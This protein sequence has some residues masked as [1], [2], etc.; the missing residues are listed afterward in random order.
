MSGIVRGPTTWSLS[1]DIDGYR[2]YTLEHL[3][4][5]SDI[6]DGP[7][8]AL[9][10]P[11][12]PISGATWIIGTEEDLFVYCTSE[13]EVT[14]IK[15]DNEPG[16]FWKVT[17]KFTNRPHKRCNDSNFDNP[18]DEPPRLSGSF[19][20]F[21]QRVFFDKDNKLLAS[22]SY[23]AF[24]VEIELPNP[25]VQIGLNYPTLP[26]ED[27]A[28]MVNSVNN[29]ALWGL[30]ARCVK[31][32]NVRWQRNIFGTCSYYYTVDYEFEINYNTWDIVQADRG[33]RIYNGSGSVTDP[34]SY[35]PYQDPKSKEYTTVYLNGSGGKLT[36]GNSPV[37]KT[38]RVYQ[39]NDFLSLGIP[40]SL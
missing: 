3:V 10:S 30:P 2:T 22:S 40:S 20:K 26:L 4:E 32:S 25:T 17:N 35:T 15:P 14:P 16:V 19:N 7:L 37:K 31:L 1:R 27:F 28:P 24:D 9:F 18:L 6:Q 39:E 34:S 8:Q 11:G 21:S 23:E 29:G 5:V 13:V 36:A 38:F 12:L 33:T